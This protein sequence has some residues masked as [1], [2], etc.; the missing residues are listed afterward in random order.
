MQ[1]RTWPD[2]AYKSIDLETKL[3]ELHIGSEAYL[4]QWISECPFC[5]A[6]IYD[7]LTPGY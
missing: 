4:Y 1:D 5:V 6:L 7:S 3:A 2:L